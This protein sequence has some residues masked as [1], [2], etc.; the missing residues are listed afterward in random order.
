[1]TN[2]YI[3][4]KQYW[5]PIYGPTFTTAVLSPLAVNVALNKNIIA[6]I[7]CGSTGPETYYDH[8]QVLLDPSMRTI[9]SCADPSV[10]PAAAMVD[11]NLST[12]WQSTSR[13][14]LYLAGYGYPNQDAIIV[15]DLEQRYEIDEILLQF[16]D[17]KRPKRFSIERSDDGINYIPWV[18]RE[19]DQADCSST[20][21]NL[22]SKV[23]SIICR[24]YGAPKE[25]NYESIRT[26]LSSVPGYLAQHY[27]V[28]NLEV[29]AECICN[30]HADA[31]DYS[32]ITGNFE[33]VCGDNTQGR[34]CDQCLP[35]F[36]QKKFKYGATCEGCNCFNH[37]DACYFNQSVADLGLSLNLE[38]KKNGGG[39]CQN[40]DH[41][42]TGINCEK[43]VDFFYRP[44][45]RSQGAGDACIPCGCFDD[46]IVMNLETGRFGDCIMNDDGIMPFGKIP[47][48]CLCKTNVA[49]PKCDQC[50]PEYFNLTMK[51]SNGCQDCLCNVPGTINSSNV[52]SGDIMGQCPCKANVIHRQCNECRDQFYNL[53]DSNTDG[54]SSCDCDVGGS[55]S[56]ICDKTSGQ[57][58]CRSDLT[59]RMCDRSVDGFY[60]VTAYFIAGEFETAVSDHDILHD[61]T[62][63]GFMGPGY[64]STQTGDQIIALPEEFAT[65]DALGSS[66]ADQFVKDC[67]ILTDGSMSDDAFCRKQMF[68]LSV[69]YMDG[70]VPCG[71]DAVGSLDKT[72]EQ[73][74]GQC[75]C[76]AGVTGR[77]CDVCMPGFYNLT[78][79][80]CQACDCAADNK[81]CLRTTG[82]CLCPAN[83][84]ERKCD[85]C[86]V[87]H[88]N[89]HTTKG[90]EACNCNATGSVSLQCTLTYG[91]CSCKPGVDGY[92]CEQ[93]ADGYNHYSESGCMDCGCDMDGSLSSVCDKGFGQCSCKTN[94]E[95]LTCDQC[96]SGTFFN[97]EDHPNGCLDCICM[98]TTSNCSS[99]SWKRQKVDLFT[100]GSFFL[101]NGPKMFSHNVTVDPATG[102]THLSANMA[103]ASTER[104]FWWPMGVPFSGN[105]LGIYKGVVSF[106]VQYT[107]QGAGT[108]SYS[109]AALL[110]K[111]GAIFYHNV[112]ALADDTMTTVNISMWEHDWSM[113][114]SS[115]NP[116]R[117]QFL[118]VLQNVEMILFPA[119]FFTGSHI[120]KLFGASYNIA[121]SNSSSMVPAL[122][123]EQCQCPTAYD[124]LSCERC[125]YGFK[126]ANVSSHDFLG[127]CV[128]CECNGHS[129]NCDADT[130]KCIACQHDTTGFNCDQ[131]QSGFYGDASVGTPTDCTACPCYSPRVVNSTCQEVGAVVKC[132]YCNTGYIGDRCDG[133]DDFYYGNP[134]VAFTGQCQRCNCNGN[135]D[136]CNITNGQC[137]S[138]GFNSDGFNCERCA[139]EFFG[140]ATTQV[141]SGCN[142]NMDGSLSKVCDYASGACQCLPGVVGRVCDQCDV[143]HYGYTYVANITGCVD[144]KCNAAGSASL[145]CDLDTGICNCHLNASGDKCGLCAF[146]SWGLPYQQCQSCSCDANGTNPATPCDRMFGQCNCRPGVR[147]RDCDECMKMHVDFSDSGCRSCDRCEFTLRSQTDQLQ[148]NWEVYWNTS[149]MVAEVMVIDK[150]M[151]AMRAGLNETLEKLGVSGQSL[152]S[153]LKR[154]DN[155]T[156]IEP[157]IN[158]S[159][160]NLMSQVYLLMSNAYQLENVT[161]EETIRLATLRQGILDTQAQLVLTLQ[162]ASKVEGDLLQH[163]KSAQEILVASK[164]IDT[165]LDITLVQNLQ[166]IVN[167][168]ILSDQAVQMTGDRLQGASEQNQ[169][170]SNLDQ[171]SHV[172]DDKYALLNQSYDGV[173]MDLTAIETTGQDTLVV[174]NE[175]MHHKEFA[176]HLF[177]EVALGL[178]YTD[179][180]HRTTVGLF[181]DGAI[182]FDEAQ[183]A[184]Q[185]WMVSSATLSTS[186]NS[187]SSVLAMNAVEVE[188]AE[189]WIVNL[190][191]HADEINRL[192]EEVKPKGETAVEAITYYET[193]VA[194]INQSLTLAMSANQ[195]MMQAMEAIDNITLL[196]LELQANESKKASEELM[197]EVA[198]SLVSSA[199]M[200]N[201]VNSKSI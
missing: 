170:L 89:W 196:N 28:R 122:G 56:P 103:G 43:C 72:C 152:G 171:Q 169:F 45:G 181:S 106:E 76:K 88:W 159:V 179:Y 61:D 151:E 146:G 87:N 185:S 51:N 57:C 138:C 150:E 16:G 66:L 97:N 83:T 149:T 37:T 175:T 129:S 5:E 178:N 90:C 112:T 158:A 168:T 41:N 193:V 188:K 46:G 113:E 78:S 79:A 104:L 77:T 4:D 176:E 58:T 192:Y 121:M 156:Q 96:K 70:G 144:C 42:T 166:I 177:L 54:C 14:Q 134:D 157:R 32:N 13:R 114:G 198:K 31:C 84:E 136:R 6:N 201:N 111:N 119:T 139:D 29:H 68:S 124:G 50:K 127:V 27:T 183:A 22:P 3:F 91:Q 59:G 99:T 8:S 52:C 153:I 98:G 160:G 184:E 17:S 194:L 154:L 137:I 143:N 199:G 23:D 20:Y 141:C 30:G 101:M 200:K 63:N 173:T 53:T 12:W 155:M 47:G 1:M 26:D 147:G 100:E 60:S 195:T 191:T 81:N 133:C 109:S 161:L 65:P 162:K 172:I 62:L 131:C 108:P 142:C 102:R 190:T 128:P 148:Q 132:S 115:R 116:S 15:I 48:D 94:T 92:K 34:Q 35:A 21:E 174:L 145:Q 9:Q 186:I 126:R 180:I 130:G 118:L 82:Q 187:T 125:A 67:G 11:G 107:A 49:G 110:G 39:V 38:G 36:N 93:C 44:L 10:R 123:V 140:D 182:A 165:Q 64:I 80:G 163:N 2:N 120:S 85:T 25:T 24:S 74:G 164:K 86:V 33:C 75:H 55:T 117:K 197:A 73:Y 71:C 69:I 40:C 7:T 95:G 105:L 135:T 18:I 19:S 189:A 167:E